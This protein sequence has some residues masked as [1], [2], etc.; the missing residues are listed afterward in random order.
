MEK[1]NKPLVFI[2]IHLNRAAQ[3]SAGLFMHLSFMHLSVRV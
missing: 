2:Y 1:K 3:P